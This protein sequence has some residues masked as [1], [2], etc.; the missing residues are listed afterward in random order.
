[1]TRRRAAASPPTPS[2]P[3]LHLGVTIVEVAEGWLLDQLMADS[4]AGRM[5]VARISERAAAVLP[6]QA[7]ALITRM[8]KLGFTPR[9]LEE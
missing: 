7:D 4:T 8:R 5:V 3:T 1:M 6:G 9:V 2:K